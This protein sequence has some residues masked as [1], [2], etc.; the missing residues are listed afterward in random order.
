[1]DWI[2][3]FLRHEELGNEMMR[4]TLGRVCF[5]FWHL[6]HCK[7]AGAINLK[8]GSLVF[9]PNQNRRKSIQYL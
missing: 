8:L 7:T 4:E 1:M 2:Q 5:I 9:E 6:F 3:L